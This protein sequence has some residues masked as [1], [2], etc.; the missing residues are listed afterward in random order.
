MISTL[1]WVPKGVPK[2]MPEPAPPTEEELEAMRRAAARAA[3]AA[4]RRGNRAHAQGGGGSSDEEEEDDAEE[5]GDTSMSDGDD[6][7]DG[8]AAVARAKR[9][10]ALFASGGGK[11]GSGS[12]GAAAAAGRQNAGSSAPQTIEEALHDLD[13]RFPE[14]AEADEDAARA[15]LIGRAFRTIADGSDIDDDDDDEGAVA[16]ADGDDDEDAAERSGDDSEDADAF[17]IRPTDM[18]ILAGR[19]EDDVSTLEVWLYE[20]ASAETGGE[21]NLYVHHDVLLPSFPLCAARV[22]LRGGGGG[23]NGASS[24]SLRGNLVAV[25]TMEP[26]ID[27]WDLDVLDAVEPLVTLGGYVKPRSAQ[28]AAEEAAAAAAE[29]EEDEEDDDGDDGGDDAAAAARRSKAKKDKKRRKDK[30]RKRRQKEAR[31]KPEL[32]EGS[33]SDAVLAVAWNPAVRNALASGSA[34]ATVKLWDLAAGGVCT[35]TLAHHRGKVQ[36]VAWNPAEAPVLLTG[37]FDRTACVVDARVAAAAPGG[38]KS[39]APPTWQT[40]AD[41]EAVAWSPGRP[42]SFVVSSEDGLVVCFD[43]RAGAGELAFFFLFFFLFFFSPARPRPPPP[44]RTRGAKLSRGFRRPLAAA[45]AGGATL[46]RCRPVADARRRT[47]GNTSGLSAS[48]S[49]CVLDRDG[50]VKYPRD[51]LIAP[52]PFFFPLSLALTPSR[53]KKTPKK[54][55]RKN[56]KQPPRIETPLAPVGARQARV[57]PLLLPR[58]PGPPRHRLD[59]QDRQAV[60]RVGR[61]RGR[62]RRGAA[63]D[64]QRAPKPGRRV[65]GG[66]LRGRCAAPARDG[67]GQGVGGRVG[68]AVGQGRREAVAGAHGGRDVSRQARDGKGGREARGAAAAGGG[69]RRRRRRRRR[70]RARPRRGAVDGRGRVER[71]RVA[72]AR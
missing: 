11:K 47:E 72:H 61:G 40:S 64:R 62:G 46:D 32:R 12:G 9:A 6:E 71:I 8:A 53:K 41:V 70:R 30:D 16:D 45:K 1:A 7:E 50:G 29:A 54:N 43:T 13:V 36:A 17:A 10:A 48:R 39:P 27:V 44:P 24:S 42:T 19:H 55:P 3:Q 68:R 52:P 25:G 35:A 18:L 49:P 21:A 33:H 67:R 2:A 23:G 63:P 57:R 38:K 15:A 34:D 26:G 31:R 56:Q 20:E 65:R 37:A 51:S 4:L 5:D 60:G 59:R 58:R 66:V 69:Q 14:D 28:A 22:D